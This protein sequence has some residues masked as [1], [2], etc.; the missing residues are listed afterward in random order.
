MITF[1][2]KSL[3]LLIKI[4]MMQG[5]KYIPLL[6]ERI[7]K[8]SPEKIIL[9]G[10]YAYG[11]PSEDS[12]I[13]I[14]VVTSETGMPANYTERSNIYL[15]IAHTISDIQKQFPVDLIVHTMGMHEKFINTNSLFCR[16]LLLNGKILYE[17]NNRRLA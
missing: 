11:T 14:L 2:T 1:Q 13:D 3:L 16:E 6:V 8:E 5:E 4:E 7:K 17:K 9:F 15:R 10:S 12:D